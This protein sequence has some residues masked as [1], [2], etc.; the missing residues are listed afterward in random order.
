MCDRTQPRRKGPGRRPV[1]LGEGSRT[2]AKPMPWI[3]SEEFDRLASPTDVGPSKGGGLW[4]LTQRLR[5]ILTG[6]LDVAARG[7]VASIVTEGYA[8]GLQL[9]AQTSLSE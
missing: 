6:A 9:Y 5:P 8:I 2:V 4:F 3:G 7:I 1:S